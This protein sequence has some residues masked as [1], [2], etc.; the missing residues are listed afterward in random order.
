M[1]IRSFFLNR[2][3]VYNLLLS[4]FILYG[5]SF[6]NWNPAR[7]IAFHWIE[8]CV[9]I[10]FFM[11]YM[12][13]VGRLNWYAEAIAGFVILLAIMCGYFAILVNMSE[14]FGF[15]LLKAKPCKDCYEEVDKAIQLFYPYYD[16]SFYIVLCGLANF[17]LLRKIF[18]RGKADEAFGYYLHMCAA[19]VLSTPALFIPA[20]LLTLTGLSLQVSTVLACLLVRYLLDRW[21]QR[22]LAYVFSQPDQPQA[23]P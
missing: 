15:V 17:H 7:I 4:L 6:L 20:G 19:M 22:H 12:K 13:W 1:Q 14:E 21:Q 9:F 3:R 2:T 8:G 11:L 23:T 18:N 16:F 10:L 5:V